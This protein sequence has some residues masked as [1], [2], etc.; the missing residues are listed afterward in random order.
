M[1]LTDR[2][3]P[4][5]FHAEQH[6]LWNSSARF[7][8]VPAGRR[9]GKTEFAKR[10]GIRKALGP[11]KFENAWYVFA[12][13][14]HQQAKRIYWDDL[15]QMVPPRL[16]LGHPRESGMLI[17]LYNGAKIQV[18]GLDKPYRIEG[19]PLD[20]ICLDEYGNMKESV[21]KD[22]VRPALSD[23]LGQ[24]MFIGVPEGR[25]HYWNTYK[26]AQVES[27]ATWEAFS[28]VSADIL[29][30]GEIEAARKELDPRSFEQEYEASF[31]NFEGRVYYTFDP[32]IHASKR[33]SY[34]PKLD[35]IFMFDFNVSP[36]VAAV[37]QEQYYRDELC[38]MILDEVWIPN[39]SNT[40]MVC[41]ELIKRWGHHKLN[42][43]AYGDPT[44]GNRGSAKLS[45][46][47]WDIIK[48]HLRGH[49]KGRYSER[50]PRHAGPEGSRI[51]AVNRRI[52]SADQT[53]RLFVNR[54]CERIIMDFEGVTYKAGI[55]EID[56]SSSPML[57]HISD[58]IGYY[59]AHR[60]PIVGSGLTVEA[61]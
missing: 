20:W 56:K 35:L 3:T 25:N 36:G 42:A 10:I 33:L 4:M 57:T 28:W 32:A 23:R 9:S 34:N 22:H 58:A 2:W 40:E 54:D 21:W 53:V 29:P 15:K 50:V 38:T 19:P 1:I 60:F 43:L 37:G 8:V 30:S 18:L 44:G 16:R 6:R 12:A 59:V 39:N 55:K 24:A 11:Q 26:F 49:F 5:D 13:P 14:T 27:N 46:S 61:A 52:L 31:L 45:G 41:K 47:D 51:N 48:T 7:Q 17:K